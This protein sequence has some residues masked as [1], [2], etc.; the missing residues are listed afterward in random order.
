MNKAKELLPNIIEA[1]DEK[2]AVEVLVKVAEVLHLSQN[3]SHLVELKDT[4]EELKGKFKNISD[5]YR[6]IPTPRPYNSLHELRMELSFLF[7]DFTDALA[8]EINK[9]KI[10]HEERKTEARAIAMIELKNDADFQKKIKATSTSA[11]RDII[12]ASSSY[13]EFIT[14]A[15]FSYGLYQE[16]QKMSDAMKMLNDSLASECREAQYNDLKDAK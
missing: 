1:N 2:G 4:M 16:Y 9:S 8:F 3:Y 7:R 13:Q 6:E 11:L 12:G 15:S 5:R 10:F 14:L